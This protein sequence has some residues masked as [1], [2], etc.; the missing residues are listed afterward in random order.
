MEWQP[1]SEG[2][3]KLPLGA[4]VGV[5]LTGLVIAYLVLGAVSFGAKTS[6]TA[7]PARSCGEIDQWAWGGV[8]TSALVALGGI[9]GGRSAR[10]AWAS[11]AMIGVV[12]LVVSTAMLAVRD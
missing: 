2:T 3:N 11:L 10:S 7:S 12:I 9:V 8:T 1:G 4:R 5:A 6:C